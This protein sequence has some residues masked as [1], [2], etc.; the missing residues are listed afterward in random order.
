[1]IA[2]VAAVSDVGEAVIGEI[3]NFMFIILRMSVGAK[4]CCQMSSY[5]VS[6]VTPKNTRSMTSLTARS[7]KCGQQSVGRRRER[8]ES[9]AGET[10]V[11]S[12]KLKSVAC[13]LSPT[14]LTAVGPNKKRE[15]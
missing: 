14:G 4:S 7:K 2:Q 15:P 9:L 8:T 11:N 12:G 6:I 5:S 13:G 1:M 10:F 3:G